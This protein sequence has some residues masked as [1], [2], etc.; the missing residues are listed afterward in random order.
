MI[1]ISWWEDEGR[2]VVTLLESAQ[3][4]WLYIKNIYDFL[5]DTYI[6]VP[7]HSRICSS[8]FS[9]CIRVVNHCLGTTYIGK[10]H[11]YEV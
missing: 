3:K 9:F 10:L 6:Y 2:L 1:P 7:N 5:K 11:F 8:Q 4:H